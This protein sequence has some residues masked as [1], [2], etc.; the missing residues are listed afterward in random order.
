MPCPLD[1]LLLN[2]SS[3]HSPSVE[4]HAEAAARQN[5]PLQRPPRCFF[6][7]PLKLPPPTLFLSPLLPLPALLFRHS[8]LIPLLSRQLHFLLQLGIRHHHGHHRRPTRRHDRFDKRPAINSP[9]TTCR[10]TVQGL[11]SLVRCRPWTTAAGSSVVGLDA[12]WIRA[13]AAVQTRGVADVVSAVGFGDDAVA[14]G[15]FVLRVEAG[16]GRRGGEGPG[17][18]HLGGRSIAGSGWARFGDDGLGLSAMVEV[19]WRKEEDRRVAEEISLPVRHGLSVKER[20]V[21]G[22][23]SELVGNACRRGIGDFTSKP[24]QVLFGDVARV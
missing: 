7:P 24:S 17:F 21:V 9:S 19:C 6:T 3:G 18:F 13:R 22:G 4:N 20:L 12:L 15:A 11:A 14:D 1:A 5:T 23:D 16:W 2:P 10:L 8:R